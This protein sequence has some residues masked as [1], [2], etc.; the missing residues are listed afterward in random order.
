MDVKDQLS[1]IVTKILG[2]AKSV[3]CTSMQLTN[4][5]MNDVHFRIGFIDEATTITEAEFWIFPRVCDD[6]VIMIGDI[7][8]FPTYKSFHIYI[9]S[10]LLSVTGGKCT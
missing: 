10:Y 1:I 5:V 4:D 6:V 3:T 8:Y 2:L 7:V 9:Y